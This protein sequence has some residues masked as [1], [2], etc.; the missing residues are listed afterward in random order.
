MKTTVT[1]FLVFMSFSLFAQFPEY[2]ITDDGQYQYLANNGSSVLDETR[3]TIYKPITI[4]TF[5]LEVQAKGYLPAG[6]TYEQFYH[7]GIEEQRDIV[8]QPFMKPLDCS[9]GQSISEGCLV[10]HGAATITSQPGTANY[11]MSRNS[12]VRR[13][14]IERAPRD[15]AAT[16]KLILHEQ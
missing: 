5:F 6:T 3:G 11:D 10:Y 9:I 1:F 16:V 15:R 4:R 2:R 7:L 8:K 14:P 13:I 12:S